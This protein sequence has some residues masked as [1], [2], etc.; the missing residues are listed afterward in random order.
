[1]K[2]F[3][4]VI[5]ETATMISTEKRNAQ[6]NGND[7][8]FHGSGEQDYDDVC[9]QLLSETNHERRKVGL[10][11]V[12]LSRRLC[13]AAQLHSQYQ[14]L[15]GKMSHTGSGGS[16]TSDRA[17]AEGFGYKVICENVASGQKSV[18]H[19]MQSWMKSEGHNR[20]IRR[21]DVERAGFGVFQ[22][23]D[24]RPYWTMV[25]GTER[26]ERRRK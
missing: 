13:R 3:L 26:S 17:K 5:I 7:E 1:M 4:K 23:A 22:S 19:V 12:T 16:R 18:G 8:H 10:N 25:L 11:D 24:G 20:N 14:A 9:K 2:S 21:P 6:T 15:H